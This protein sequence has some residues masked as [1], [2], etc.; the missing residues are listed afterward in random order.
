MMAI[1]LFGFFVVIGPPFIKVLMGGALLYA[2]ACLIWGLRH[3]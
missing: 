1:G 2:F 3:A